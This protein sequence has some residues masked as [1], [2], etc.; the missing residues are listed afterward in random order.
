MY[1]ILR[2][3]RSG[4]GPSPIERMARGRNNVGLPM[5]A[6]APQIAEVEQSC[7]G[8]V[9][10]RILAFLAE[11]PQQGAP[12]LDP[13]GHARHSAALEQL[14]AAIQKE[15]TP[16]GAIGPGAGDRSAG[17]DWWYLVFRGGRGVE[18]F[19]VWDGHLALRP[20]QGEERIAQAEA[21]YGMALPPSF[22][23]L[24]SVFDQV[25]HNA[26]H[27]HEGTVGVDAGASTKGFEG[28]LA[29]IRSW[30]DA[31]GELAE[32]PAETLDEYL[33]FYADPYG[34]VYL[35]ARQNPGPVFKFDHECC[36]IVETGSPDFDSFFADLLS[37]RLG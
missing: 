30:F 33:P 29:N 1:R 12:W 16:L 5:Q 27:L 6:E 3:G 24:L 14:L 4:G 9:P 17:R 21:R 13:D 15:F 28:E 2:P 25:L 26:L 32:T 8:S 19:M 20:S 23:H 22:R 11:Y 18:R 10:E 37:G 31:A 35:F 36:A 7:G 34:N